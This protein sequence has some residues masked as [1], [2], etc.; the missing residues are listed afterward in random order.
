MAV[1]ILIVDDEENIRAM[2]QLMLE[3][4][5]YAVR[6]AENGAIALA[7]IKRDRP[8]LILLDVLM[9]EMDGYTFY[10]EIKKNPST[11]NIPVLI[12]TARG[13]MEDSF[14]V[15]GV[16]GFLTKPVLP[17]ELLSE[18]EHILEISHIR[19]ET[20]SGINKPITKR[21]LLVGGD[22]EILDQMFF[23]AHRLDFECELALNG[24]DAIGKAIK[25]IPGLIFIEVPFPDMPA[26]EIVAILRRLPH[27]EETPL[28]GYSYYS[29]NLLGDPHVR[30]KLLR[31]EESSYQFLKAGATHFMGRYNH[32]LFI[33]TIKD[34][35]FRKKAR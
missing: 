35:A 31:I 20:S 22:R 8:D 27:F 34:F 32:R 21:L 30:Q 17:Q 16:D 5:G 23:Q 28:I 24:S 2:A 19:Q 26:H 29:T 33:Q 18:I 6:T 10:K 4:R 7:L 25:V 1:R 9:P 11:Q 3:K 12:I 13:M 15:M 14:K